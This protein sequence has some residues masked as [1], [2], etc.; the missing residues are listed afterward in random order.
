MAS[1]E[2]GCLQTILGR[3]E[4]WASKSRNLGPS[5]V[6]VNDLY[7]AYAFWRF[8]CK[9]HT[10]TFWT[11]GFQTPKSILWVKYTEETPNLESHSKHV[12]HSAWPFFFRLLT[13]HWPGTDLS[14]VTW[15]DLSKDAMARSH[16][17]FELAHKIHDIE[18]KGHQLD[19]RLSQAGLENSVTYHGGSFFFEWRQLTRWKHTLGWRQPA[20]SRSGSKASQNDKNK[21]G[22][23]RF[24][25]KTSWSWDEILG[26]DGRL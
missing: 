22:R 7:K 13:W 26:V 23:H 12:L 8:Y 6:K 19:V 16:E 18:V 21:F 17:A 20:T 1:Q 24:S 10:A 15:G 11:L 4:G 9:G 3:D 14:M 25:F 5:G 2:T